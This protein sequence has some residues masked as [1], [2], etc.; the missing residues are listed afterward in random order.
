MIGGVIGAR[1]F[2]VIQYWDE[3]ERIPAGQRLLA[4]VKLTEGGLVI[5]G[6][7]VGGLLAGLLYCVLYRLPVLSFADLITPGFLLGQ[8][9][10]R[11][12]CFLNGCCFGGICAADLPTVQFPQGSPPYVV[13]LESGRLLGVTAHQKA[14]RRPGRRRLYR[15]RWQRTNCKPLRGD[16]SDSASIDSTA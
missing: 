6:G 11:I 12:G 13:S 8:A 16:L 10:G 9:F 1:A 7:M 15:V 5:Y 3:F 14:P 2:F 4:V